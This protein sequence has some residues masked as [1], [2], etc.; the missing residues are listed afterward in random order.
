M[1]SHIVRLPFLHA[2]LAS[3]II[4]FIGCSNDVT[5]DGWTLHTLTEAEDVR[6]YALLDEIR[7]DISAQDLLS[8]R[9]AS[10]F[11]E[12][13]SLADKTKST[14]YETTQRTLCSLVAAAR[15]SLATRLLLSRTE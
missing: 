10:E 6:Q 9:Q 13:L 12:L 8:G 14:D 15:T 2:V 5:P 3:T 1:H 11:E 4:T 7:W